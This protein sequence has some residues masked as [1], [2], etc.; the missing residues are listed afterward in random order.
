[1]LKILISE[2]WSKN[3]IVYEMQRV[4]GQDVLIHP[5]KLDDDR[6]FTHKFL[7]FMSLTFAVGGAFVFRRMM[8]IKKSQIDAVMNASKAAEMP[9]R[10]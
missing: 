7:P 5:Q 8:Q 10:Q 4:F 2:G 9:A 1:M 3:E 6:T